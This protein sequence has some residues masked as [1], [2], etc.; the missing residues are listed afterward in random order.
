[1]FHTDSENIFKKDSNKLLKHLTNFTFKDSTKLKL[2]GEIA[3]HI[4]NKH[5]ADVLWL[6]KKFKLNFNYP[7]VEECY[8]ELIERTTY[9]PLDLFDNYSKNK[10]ENKLYYLLRCIVLKK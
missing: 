6:K 4:Y 9:S 3:Q 2:K 10:A 1:M 8:N 7:D 5:K